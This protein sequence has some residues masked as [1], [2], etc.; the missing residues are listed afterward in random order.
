MFWQVH[1]MKK[2]LENLLNVE[3]KSWKKELT[4]IKEYLKSFGDRVPDELF[5]Q[6]SEI[7]CQLS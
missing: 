1:K 6:L 3:N 4:D 7:E 5:K 2:I